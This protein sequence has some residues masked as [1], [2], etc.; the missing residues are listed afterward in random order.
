MWRKAEI[1]DNKKSISLDV[2]YFLKMGHSLFLNFRLFNTIDSKQMFN[3]FFA[4]DWIQTR[5][6]W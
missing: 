6:L 4:Y 2:Y 5:D 3:E 1:Q